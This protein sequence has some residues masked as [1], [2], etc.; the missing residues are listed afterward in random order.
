[1]R[2]MDEKVGKNKILEIID[3][4][5]IPGLEKAIAK[6]ITLLGGNPTDILIAGACRKETEESEKK[7]PRKDLPADYNETERIIH[8]MLIENTG[9]HPLDSGGIYG[10]HWERNRAIRDFRETPEV[11]VSEDGV[12][13]N[14]FHY[15]TCYLERD[16]LSEELEKQLYEFAEEPENRDLSWFYVMEGFA[17][18]LEDLGWIVH[19]PFN[20]YNSDNFLSQVLQG[21]VVETPDREEYYIILQIHNGCDVRG[22]YT[23]PR[24]FKLLEHEEFFFNMTEVI[25]GCGCRGGYIDPSGY[26]EYGDGDYDKDDD[27]P[28]DWQWEDE[29]RRYVCRSCGKPVKFS[30]HI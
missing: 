24:I 11:Y 18:Q 3:R 16:E 26:H 29:N 19:P 30:I 28:K 7:H 22:G 13:I 5:D 1:M 15:L 23:K 10:R 12:L 20:T 21:I 6:M 4:L 17:D 9:A 8:E 25:A 14:V 2:N 27:L